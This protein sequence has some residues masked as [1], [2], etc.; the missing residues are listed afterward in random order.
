VQQNTTGA[1]RRPLLLLAT[2]TVTVTV[3]VLLAA[4]TM[5]HA[6]PPDLKSV[7]KLCQTG[8]YEDC[9]AAAQQALGAGAWTE[10]WHLLLIHGL[11]ALGRTDSAASAAETL[12]ARYMDSL[13]ALLALHDVRRATGDRRAADTLERMRKLFTTPGARL[14]RA[15]ELVV[16]GQVA[17]RLGDEPRA[18]LETYFDPAAK[19]DPSY[20][21]TYLAAGTLALDKHDDALAAQ[22][23][24]QGMA[25]LGPDADLQLGLARS[26]QHSDTK[27]MV[28]ALD[29][30]LKMNPRL[31]PALL[32]RAEHAVDGEDFAGA[33][34]A[35]EAA[36]AVDPNHPL[37]W[38]FEAV[39]AHLRNDPAGETRA[40]ERALLRWAANPEVDVL[41]G[42]KLS[43]KYR[44]AEGAAYQRRALKF[45]PS[46]VPA[47]MA[48]AS[49]LLRLGRESEGWALVDEVRA[50]DG[51]DVVAFNLAGLRGH[52][53]KMSTLK[54]PDFLVRMDPR[55]AAVWGDAAVELLREARATVDRKY[56]A[57][58]VRPVTVEIFADQS[59]FAVRTFGLP[60]GAA[61]LGVCFGPL[62][63]MN[64]PSGNS[65]S[66]ANWKAV[67]WHEYTHV[68]TLGLT[69]NKMPRWLSE[70]ISV[71]EEG[72]RDPSWGQG[73]TPRFRDMI[74]G[75]E[76][77]PVGKLSAAFLEAKDGD[78]LMFAYY[79]SS[80]LVELVVEKYGFA[81]LKAVLHDL[82][83]GTDVN[84]ALAARVAPLPELER[85]FEAFAKG[86]ATALG[87]DADWTRPDPLPAKGDP[88]AVRRWLD[89]HP[90]SVWAL[91]EEADRLIAAQQWAPAKAML[92]RLLAVDPDERGGDSAYLL[93]ANVQRK[94][95]EPAAEAKT[96]DRLATLSGDAQ[97]AFARLV[98]LAQEA[99]DWPALAR[100]A[101]R[102]LAVNPMSA[103]GYR[104]LARSL[105]ERGGNE[106]RAAD[107]YRTVLRLDPADPADIHLR[108]A[109]LLRRRDPRAARRHVLDALSEAPRFREAHRLLLEMHGEAP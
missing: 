57:T 42:R 55:D 45:D 32:L 11:S 109:R 97:P 67:L 78:H 13:S 63:T 34:R 61:Y 43:E 92:E 25:K 56:G 54:S 91:R 23:F 89:K 102:L 107:A 38:A 58:P 48:L 4:G 2:A 44:F 62:I 64:S 20:R 50:R 86:R 79:Q 27:A 31:V 101:E 65:G 83:S 99:R 90:K 81:A 66:T 76:L 100:N 53:D 52:L 47:K 14:Q 24:R 6:A 95:N 19:K 93:L 36:R 46:W 73:M 17:L 70:G 49:D 106:S 85:A 71:Y 22:W 3:T 18:V 5:A 87:H 40:R 60:G 88:V 72:R 59:D 29:G 7:R 75:G 98:E 103:T 15:D 68:V 104:G 108:L 21:D 30:A 51:Y 8:H 9:V 41:I 28:R 105:E 74:L 82:A 1:C 16:A 96:L 77:T 80:L 35:L 94:L 10:E 12:E 69:H 84:Q 26:F 33:H 39:L 37:A